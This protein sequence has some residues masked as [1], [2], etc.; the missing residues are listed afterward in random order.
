MIAA[1]LH[2]A[3]QLVVEHVLGLGMQ[4]RVDG[5]HVAHLDQRLDIRMEG[6][7]ELLLHLLGQ[8]VLVV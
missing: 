7:A 2:H 5:H 3:D 8:A 4:R 6:E 1:A